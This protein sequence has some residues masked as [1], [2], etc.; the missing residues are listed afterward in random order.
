MGLRS[1]KSKRGLGYNLLVLVQILHK[2][3]KISDKLGY[4]SN[5]KGIPTRG[6]LFWICHRNMMLPCKHL[7]KTSNAI[8]DWCPV[9][10]FS[11]KSYHL[12]NNVTTDLRTMNGMWLVFFNIVTLISQHAMGFTYND[13]I[14][15]KKS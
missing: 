1:G 3:N 8:F 12:R 14:S 6:T 7:I 2:V 13:Q 9:L 10:N 15:T 4:P 11:W 5:R